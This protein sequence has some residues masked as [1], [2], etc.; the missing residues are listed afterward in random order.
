MEAME[1]K[2]MRRRAE[3]QRSRPVGVE[4]MMEGMAEQR[5]KKKKVVKK[6]LIQERFLLRTP[7]GRMLG[8]R[9]WRHLGLVPPPGSQPDLL[10]YDGNDEPADRT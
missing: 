4:T 10:A 8:E 2:Y 1:G 3:D 6:F 7:R 9:G 5:E